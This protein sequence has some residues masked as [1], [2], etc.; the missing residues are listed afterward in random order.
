MTS[1]EIDLP[2]DDDLGGLTDR[3]SSVYTSTATK[4]SKIDLSS[5]SF[6]NT[7]PDTVL[8]GNSPIKY[9]YLTFETDLPHPSTGIISTPTGPTPPSPN[10]KKFISPFEWPE[11]RKNGILWLSCIAT[12]ITAATAGSYSPAAAQ[13]SH[14]WGVSTVAVVV[15]ITTFCCGF[16]IAPMVLAP[17]SEINGRYPVFVAAG[18]LFFVCQLCCAVTHS[19][20]GMLVAR[21]F[22]GCGSSVFST[23]V[24]GVVSDLYHAK[25][26]NTPMALFSG[27]AL[28]GTGLGPLMAGFLAENLNWRWVFWV[29]TILVGVLIAIITLFFSETRGSI[30]LSRKAACLNKWYEE[31]EKA[32]YVGFEMPGST[33]GEKMSSQ[34]IR[35]KV[36]SDEERESIVKMISISVYRPFHLLFTE[37]VVFFFSLVS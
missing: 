5:N 22:V 13:M 20:P 6:A 4:T 7:S 18:I 26:R 24:G 25:D 36:K 11:R 37:P 30:I 12:L 16:A 29:Q 28:F 34:R 19:Y 15:G 9:H 1:H 17:F 2:Y 35:W 3:D 32:G 10:L 27:G 31:R 21:F 14:E 23:M 33:D 8:D